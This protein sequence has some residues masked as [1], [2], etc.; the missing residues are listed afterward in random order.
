MAGQTKGEN[1]SRKLVT[2]VLNAYSQ[3]SQWYCKQSVMHDISVQKNRNKN[4]RPLSQDYI[5]FI[6][7]IIITSCRIYDAFMMHRITCLDVD[8]LL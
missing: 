7:N 4:T 5:S 2:V 1:S 8:H 6:Y 3:G